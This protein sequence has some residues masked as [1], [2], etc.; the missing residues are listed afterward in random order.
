[1]PKSVFAETCFPED[2]EIEDSEYGY[3]EKTPMEISEEE[4][5]EKTEK[6]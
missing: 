1:V 2:R 5:R 4:R 3:A 6:R